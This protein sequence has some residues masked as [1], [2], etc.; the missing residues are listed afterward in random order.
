LR[1][2]RGTGTWT[3]Y[4]SRHKTATD[5]Q[6][7]SPYWPNKDHDKDFDVPVLDQP[8]SIN[9]GPVSGPA[10]CPDAGATERPQEKL[11]LK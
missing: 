6:K 3:K 11:Y 2:F 8:V 10:L 5:C 1:F 7:T 9:A 4:R